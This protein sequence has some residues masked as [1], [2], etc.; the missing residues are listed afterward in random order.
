MG[1]TKDILGKK[2]FVSESFFL[3]NNETSFGFYVS[4]AKTE[5]NDYM[6]NVLRDGKWFRYL[7]YVWMKRLIEMKIT[8]QTHYFSSSLPLLLLSQLRTNASFSFLITRASN[9]SLLC[10]LLLLVREYGWKTF[11]ETIE[12]HELERTYRGW[13]GGREKQEWKRTWHWKRPDSNLSS[14]NLVMDTHLLVLS[15][16]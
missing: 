5:S 3:E 7:K 13:Q 6:R 1:S 12:I 11:E 14:I 4:V 9:S 8:I 2:T 15:F 16:P 10:W